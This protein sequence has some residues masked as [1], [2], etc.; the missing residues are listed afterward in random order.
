MNNLAR[1]IG[2]WYY[3][4]EWAEKLSK[5][6]YEEIPEKAIFKARRNGMEFMLIDGTYIRFLKNITS[7]RGIALTDSYIQEGMDYSSFHKLISPATK[8]GA[9]GMYVINNYDD[10]RHPK[11]AEQYYFE[12]ILKN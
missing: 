4:E 10:I 1:N 5:K 12:R 9:K 8:I 2:I 7:N 11:D 6:I 3:D